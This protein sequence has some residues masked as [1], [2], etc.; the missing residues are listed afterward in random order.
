MESFKPNLTAFYNLSNLSVIDYKECNK[1]LNYVFSQIK[2]QITSLSVGNRYYHRT[3]PVIPN[4]PNLL[5][6]SI[7]DSHLTSE[8]GIVNNKKINN[9]YLATNIVD[10]NNLTHL[11][12]QNLQWNNDNLDFIL[13]L[14]FLKYFYIKI[15]TRKTTQKTV[16][17]IF[18]IYYL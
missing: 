2:E 16:R 3:A 15:Y 18:F 10:M 8:L 11:T 9:F 13:L 12:L 4:F 7:I 6:L 17:I 14:K 1:F 5:K